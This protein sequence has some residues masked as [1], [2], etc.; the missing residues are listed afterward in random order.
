MIVGVG[1]VDSLGLDN[2][3]AMC[4]EISRELDYVTDTNTALITFK[5]GRDHQAQQSLLCLLTVDN[6]I[7]ECLSNNEP[8]TK[9]SLVF[10]LLS[11]QRGL[12]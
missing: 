1:C 3:V 11:N 7:L 5:I 2:K 4:G 12:E 9:Q 10:S 8:L 6:N